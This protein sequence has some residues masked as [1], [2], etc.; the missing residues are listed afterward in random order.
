MYEIY[1]LYTLIYSMCSPPAQ[2]QTEISRMIAVDMLHN[3][4]NPRTERNIIPPNLDLTLLFDNSS[5]SAALLGNKNNNV[6][7][8]V[9]KIEVNRVRRQRPSI[10]FSRIASLLTSQILANK[11]PKLL[12][13]T[14]AILPKVVS[15]EYDDPSAP[16]GHNLV[17]IIHTGKNCIPDMYAVITSSPSE[18]K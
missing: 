14:K 4:D 16:S 15:I 1:L 17:Y 11:L 3:N 18:N 12:A 6:S 2:C 5:C 8:N 9:L 10:L 13:Q 7:G